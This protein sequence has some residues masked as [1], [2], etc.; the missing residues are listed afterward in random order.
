M[1]NRYRVTGAGGVLPGGFNQK[2]IAQRFVNKQKKPKPKK[3]VKK[4]TK[5]DED[6]AEKKT[7]LKDEVDEKEVEKKENG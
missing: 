1:N 3:E 7:I 4:T 5:E 2:G 6:D